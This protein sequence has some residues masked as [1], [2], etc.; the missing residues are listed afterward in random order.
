MT[1]IDNHD[2]YLTIVVPR[3][4]DVEAVSWESE[5]DALAG[6]RDHII[7]NHDVLAWDWSPDWDDIIDIG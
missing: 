3:Q 1:N 2:N 4:L 6:L 5:A 7:E